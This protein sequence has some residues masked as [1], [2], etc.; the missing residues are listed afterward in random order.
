MVSGSR[1]PGSARQLANA[2]EDVPPGNSGTAPGRAASKPSKPS[3]SVVEEED[4]DVGDDDDD[5][6][7]DEAVA[8]GAQ[9][10]TLCALVVS[11]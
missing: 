5:S 9:P 11:R 1:Q 10:L 7:E 8:E 2:D 6:K 3:A 4:N